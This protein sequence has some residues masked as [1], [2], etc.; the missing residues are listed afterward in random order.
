MIKLFGTTDTVYTTNGDVILQPL[1]A[2]VRCEDNGQ[3]YLDL[4]TGLEYVD[5]LTEGRIVAADTPAGVQ[6]FRVANVQKTNVKITTRCPHVYYDSRNYLIP[7]TYI[8]NKGANAALDQLNNAAVGGAGSPFTTVSDVG[9]VTSYRCVRKSLNDAIS[10]VVARWGGHL[11]REKWTIALRTTIGADNGVVVRYGKNI[12]TI[13]SSEDWSEVATKILPTGKDGIKL[14]AVDPDADIYVTADQ[15]YDIPY[16]KAVSFNQSLSRDDYDTDEDFTEALVADL[17]QQATEYL[18]THQWPKVNY[19]VKT[20]LDAVTGLGDT[21]EVIDERLGLN[22][23]TNV[24]AYEYDC[25]LGKYT[26][27]ELGNFQQTIT[28]LVETITKSVEKTVNNELT[29]ATAVLN[30]ELKAATAEI[31]AGFENSYV[32]YEGNQILVVDALP[33]ENAVNCIRINRAG[34]G[35][36]TN[37]ISGPF[38]SAWTIDGKMDMQQ[39]NVL[40]LTADLI[41]GN[42]LTLGGAFYPT[43]GEIRLYDAAGNLIGI[44]GQNGVKMLGGVGS[45]ELGRPYVLMNNTVGF[46]GFDENDNKTYWADG[47]SFYMRKALAKEELTICDTMRFIKIDLT[48]NKGIGLV[49]AE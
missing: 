14:N 5:V 43:P 42:T 10:E 19:T 18:N 22:L 41:H 8:V 49:S 20:N 24:I 29:T 17:Y 39:I 27:I 44:I 47:D 21:V 34:I 33:K 7:D 30:E 6:P 12:Q 25:I 1:K 2:K 13:T 45:S 36:S 32:I 40:N 16:V 46:A 3:Y 23:M 48:N 4:E 28:G 35:F 26:N 9:V 31:L 15:Q 38:N 37:G 11:V